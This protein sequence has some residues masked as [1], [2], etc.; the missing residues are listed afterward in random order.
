LSCVHRAARRA[1]RARPAFG[2][3]QTLK[4]SPP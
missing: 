3:E 4:L 1:A 2:A